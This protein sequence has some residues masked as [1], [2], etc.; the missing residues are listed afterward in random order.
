MASPIVDTLSSTDPAGKDPLSTNLR[1][2]LKYEHSI[3]KE[4]AAFRAPETVLKEQPMATP[5]S[6]SSSP[7]QSQR[8]QRKLSVFSHNG[9]QQLDQLDQEIL[10]H[11][12]AQDL[13]VQ[14]QK[15]GSISKEAAG[16]NE[17]GEKQISDEKSS[18]RTT[19]TDNL[20]STGSSR[21]SSCDEP[22]IAVQQSSESSVVIKPTV[23]SSSQS[24]NELSS[25]YHS[26]NKRSS[27]SSSS[28]SVNS[29]CDAHSS[30]QSAKVPKDAAVPPFESIKTQLKRNSKPDAEFMRQ[31]IDRLISQNEAI[32]DNCNLVMIRSY[33][34]NNNNSGPSSVQK[35]QSSMVEAPMI[36]DPSA[37][38]KAKSQDSIRT[39]RKAKRWSTTS[40]SSSSSN[41]LGSQTSPT[42]K[43]SSPTR[44][45]I[46]TQRSLLERKRPFSTLEPVTQQ[47]LQMS[48]NDAAEQYRRPE[49]IAELGLR[50]LSLDAHRLDADN[51]SQQMF[52]NQRLRNDHAS[53]NEEPPPHLQSQ[54]KHQQEQDAIM[55]AWYERQQ[56]QLDSQL[57][58]EYLARMMLSN[59]S[60]ALNAL[61]H[62][63]I[64]NMVSLSAQ[65]QQQQSRQPDSPAHRCDACDISFWTQDLLNYHS[66]TQCTARRGPQLARPVAFNFAGPNNFDSITSRSIASISGERKDGCSFNDYLLTVPPTVDTRSPA[67]RH[68]HHHISYS[69]QSKSASPPHRRS[70]QDDQT[71]RDEEAL[72]VLLSQAASS[73]S[74]GLN[75]PSLAGK[76]GESVQLS[77]LKNKL[78]ES[79]ITKHTTGDQLDEP[80]NL[81]KTNTTT[82]TFETK[83]T[84]LPFKKR[85]ISEPNLRY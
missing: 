17:S 42:E 60:N 76:V 37:Q 2:P 19:R 64:P 74:Y 14:V 4:H 72:N 25:D 69:T 29:I 47:E 51:I 45:V 22:T 33:N 73:S 24:E 77:I 16:N 54:Q 23:I 35:R 13:Q 34:N 57:L 5:V 75:Y 39:P 43:V 31:H 18:Q 65:Q 28:S 46:T 55:K 10:R 84:L 49:G 83:S 48:S 52:H 7:K 38:D 1:D 62:T 68:S 41:L 56:Q 81:S 3:H 78:M 12:G 30:N 27:V 36:S 53:T 9:F 11:H 20:G 32:I 67:H 82:Q 21:A 58:N 26:S 15:Q 6:N 85:K 8:P 63:N 80:Y 66:L 61:I 71:R 59:Q 70:N 79:G 50:N 44:Q 40:I